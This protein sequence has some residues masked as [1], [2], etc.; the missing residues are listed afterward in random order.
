MAK[1][2]HPRYLRTSQAAKILHVS[3]RTV[4]RWA[5]SGDLPHIRTPGNHLRLQEAAVRAIA[6]GME[7]PARQTTSNDDQEER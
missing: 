3:P 1:I 7:C 4:A 2:Q 5:E 6:A